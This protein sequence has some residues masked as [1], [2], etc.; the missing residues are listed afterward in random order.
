MQIFCPLNHE[1]IQAKKTAYV[2]SEESIETVLKDFDFKT[3]MTVW[4]AK[5]I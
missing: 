1:I 4:T 2:E 5:E 3:R